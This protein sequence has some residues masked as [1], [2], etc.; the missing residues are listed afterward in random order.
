MKLKIYKFSLYLKHHYDLILKNQT[1]EKSSTITKIV[2]FGILLLFISCTQDD[3]LRDGATSEHTEEGRQRFI[4]FERLTKQIGTN[5]A[6]NGN[7]QYFDRNKITHAGR[8]GEFVEAYI[9]TEIIHLIETETM[10]FYTLRII[11]NNPEERTNIFYNLVFEEH[12]ETGEVSS[13]IIQYH[14]ELEW[15]FDRSQ[16]FRGDIIKFDNQLI[17][18]EDLSGGLIL[19]G[20]LQGRIVP[21]SR[22]EEHTSELQSRPHLVCRLLLEKKKKITIIQRI[23]EEI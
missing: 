8:G 16:L 18:L 23:Y 5:A 10:N 9:D 12:L 7:I 1:N 17:S 3:L 21:C 14:P 22:S 6:F 13:V 19:N 11:N 15:L 4:S 20:E 2:S